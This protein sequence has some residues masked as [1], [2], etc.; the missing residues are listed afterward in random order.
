[1]ARVLLCKQSV[2]MAPVCAALAETSL[3]CL[4]QIY[5]WKALLYKLCQRLLLWLPS[6]L[7]RLA[8]VRILKDLCMSRLQNMLPISQTLRA[9][10]LCTGT[11]T[12]VQILDS[13]MAS[14]SLV[15]LQAVCNST[16]CVCKSHCL[17]RIEA[18]ADGSSLIRT[19]V[20]SSPPA[21][22]STPP[23]NMVSRQHIR[24]RT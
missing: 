19:N 13:K 5:K 7:L 10:W 1:M 3:L 24:C 15:L 12:H 4:S 20:L 9:V 11:I 8:V 21:S 22:C 23:R 6:L 2:C 14:H 18:A 17:C 16:S